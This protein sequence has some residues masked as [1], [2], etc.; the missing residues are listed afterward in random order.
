MA[1][2]ATTATDA[3]L[4]MLGHLDSIGSSLGR[5]GASII[6]EALVD[7]LSEE[8]RHCEGICASEPQSEQSPEATIVC[9]AEERIRRR[10]R[11]N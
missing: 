6:C 8:F 2:V 4:P 3:L 7:W 5:S 9:L 1:K 11:Q 10:S